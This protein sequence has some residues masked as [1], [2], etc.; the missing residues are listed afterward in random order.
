MGSKIFF[1]FF[2]IIFS[3]INFALSL[4]PQRLR[5]RGDSAWQRALDAKSASEAAS[6]TREANKFY[7][8]AYNASSD[9]L[10]AASS[11][12]EAAYTSAVGS[13]I[14]EQPSR[15]DVSRVLRNELALTAEKECA[16][17]FESL[18]E[19]RTCYGH[20]Q[21]SQL[22]AL[23]ML[24]AKDLLLVSKAWA[25]DRRVVSD[26]RVVTTRKTQYDGPP[27]PKPP[28]IK[29][30]V[31]FLSASFGDH[32]VGHH[33]TPLLIHLNRSSFK[34]CCFVSPLQGRVDKDTTFLQKNRM[35]CDEWVELESEEVGLSAL[36]SQH[37]SSST[38]RSADLISSFNLD[39]LITLDGFDK[40]N[41]MD[42]LSLR[43]APC[44]LSFFGYLATTGATYIDGI[45]A[46]EI[47]IP[48]SDEA[49]YSENFIVRHPVTFF[50]NNYWDLH[51]EVLQINEMSVNQHL[52]STSGEIFSLMID[53]SPFTFC[54][55]SQLFKISRETLYAWLSILNNTGNS[56]RLV[57]LG[58]PPTGMPNLH[59]YFIC[60]GV[61]H[62][63]EFLPILPKHEHLLHKGRI[64]DLGL[65]TF[66][67][68][69]HTTVADLLW[70]GVP[71]LTYADSNSSMAGKAAASIVKAAGSPR[72]FYGAKSK[73]EY[74]Q[75][76]IDI[77]NAY[78]NKSS[79]QID[80][81]S[82]Q[83]FLWRPSKTSE[84]FHT[85]KWVKGFENVLREGVDLCR[86]RN[87]D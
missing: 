29:M 73:E 85:E 24:N 26:G 58:Y 27:A 22:V 38:K 68:N 45:I 4:S 62:R 39:I 76:A 23:T 20:S 82:V 37:T 35:A 43:P 86:I 30:R 13:L 9:P 16:V 64:C 72:L 84:L 80:D 31:G 18:I 40:G 66:Y 33:I 51:P 70:A 61:G 5:T 78:I 87:P 17:T 12:Y 1:C 75:S 6:A 54:S 8:E 41:R 83:E 79:D 57:L 49:Y 32:P 7:Y 44:I 77:F 63:V 42:I 60:K 47:S 48:I 2:S 25:S 14:E 50:V 19:N 15:D 36:V 74:V 65:D 34:V 59:Q 67:Y 28:A 71:V 69:G 11:F 53:T 52:T 81:E 46:D 3:N 56:S 21:I 10:F 55:F